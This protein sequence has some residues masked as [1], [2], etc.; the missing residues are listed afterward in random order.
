MDLQKPRR[1]HN[2]ISAADALVLTVFCLKLFLWRWR[3]AQSTEERG[4]E[5]SKSERLLEECTSA[6]LSLEKVAI[7]RKDLDGE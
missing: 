6:E 3:G 7:E 5:V 2:R 1:S 4:R